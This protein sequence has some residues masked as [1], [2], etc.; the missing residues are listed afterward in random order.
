M[1][2]HVKLIVNKP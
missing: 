2:Y 1:K